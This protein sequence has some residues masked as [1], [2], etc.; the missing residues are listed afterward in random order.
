[1]EQKDKKTERIEQAEKVASV[2]DKSAVKTDE[3]IDGLKKKTGDTGAKV[4]LGLI[5]VAILAMVKDGSML[6]ILLGV[7]AILFSGKIIAAYKKMAT[8][9]KKEEK[10]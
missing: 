7:M 10:K 8:S 3:F 6:W 5:V 1:M 4:Q 2:I 9:E